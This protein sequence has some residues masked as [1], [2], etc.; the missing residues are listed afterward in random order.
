[1]SRLTPLPISKYKKFLEHV[2]CVFKRQKGDHLIY[3][4]DGLKRPVVFPYD[5]EIPVFIIRNN[6]RT[7][8]ISVS[9]YQNILSKI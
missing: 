5:K 2:G 8:G 1:M 6:L 4:R 3:T 9:D 7:L